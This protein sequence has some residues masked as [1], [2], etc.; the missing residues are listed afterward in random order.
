LDELDQRFPRAVETYIVDAF[1]GSIR[2]ITPDGTVSTNAQAFS[3]SNAEASQ[4]IISDTRGNLYV[5]TSPSL[6]LKIANRPRI[7]QEAGAQKP[8]V[9]Y[10]RLSSE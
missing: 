4:R 1:D 6:I 8:V 3:G 7:R 2:R 9:L 5:T 10:P